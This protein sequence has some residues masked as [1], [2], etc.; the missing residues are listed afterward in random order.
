MSAAEEKLNGAWWMLRVG[1]GTGAFLA[2]LDKFFDLLTTWSM[3][4][5]P[6]AERLLPV[7]AGVFMRAV[8]AVEAL[9]G[10]AILTRWTRAGAW[11]MAAWL[12]AIAANLV[13]AGSFRDRSS[14]SR[15]TFPARVS[16][17]ALAAGCLLLVLSFR[18]SQNLGAAYGIV[19]EGLMELCEIDRHGYSS[20]RRK[21]AISCVG[22]K[23]FTIQPVAPAA[24][25]SRTRRRPTRMEESRLARTACAAL[26]SMVMTSLAWTTSMGRR[27]APG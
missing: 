22:S 17:M 23:G 4:L 13:A 26:S 5:S 20:T 9:L 21:V 19:E 24:L 16:S 8:G 1:L 7:S 10:L 2:G 11:A 12:L 25:P 3:Y 6:L 15:A 18:S 27:R 14:R